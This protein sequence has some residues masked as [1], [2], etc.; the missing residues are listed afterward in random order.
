MR[1][2]P[3]STMTVTRL[4]ILTMMPSVYT[5]RDDSFANSP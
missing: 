3:V 4:D 2:S 1:K 5:G